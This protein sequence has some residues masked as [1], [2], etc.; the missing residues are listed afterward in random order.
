M[1][2]IKEAEN[3][4]TAVQMGKARLESKHGKILSSLNMYAV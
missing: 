1:K 3:G 2:E 4:C